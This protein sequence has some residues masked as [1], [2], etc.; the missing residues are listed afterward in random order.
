MEFCRQRPGGGHQWMR[1]EH[2]YFK[3]VKNVIGGQEGNV[4]KKLGKGNFLR[5]KW[6]AFGAPKQANCQGGKENH[7]YVLGE[8]FENPVE[9]EPQGRFRCVFFEPV[10]TFSHQESTDEIKTDNSND[11][12]VEFKTVFRKMGNQDEKRKKKSDGT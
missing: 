6:N 3:R 1:M 4:E 11:T 2:S 9:I 12:Q 5:Q 7:D 10:I 8:E